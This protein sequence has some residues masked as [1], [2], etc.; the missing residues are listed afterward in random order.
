M[1]NLL[2]R[3]LTAVVAVPLLILAINWSDPIAVQ[4]IVVA[5]TGVG[6][7][8]W[9]RMTMT[10]SGAADR[11]FAIA[12]GIALVAVLVW[13]G[14]R[15]MVYPM[16]AAAATIAVLLFHLFHYGAM[17]TVAARASFA[18]A[19]LFYCGLLGFLARLKMRPDGAGW[20]YIA[21]TVSWLSDTGAYFAG[22]FLG[23]LWPAKLYPSVSPKKT[24]I[25][26][27]GGIAASYLSVLLAKLWYLPSLSWADTVLIAVPANLLGQT[28]DLC[29]SLVKRSVGVKDSGAL[30]PGHGG[31][32]DR[33]DA[34]LFVCP[35]VLAYATWVF[36]RI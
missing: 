24:I 6:L 25:G 19:G 7:R 21:L 34:L 20:V 9:M 32:L 14:D 8:E 13:L 30:L 28:G 23:P 27:F 36:G 4:L 35:Y 29:E 11:G 15:P 18:I 22:R 12:V 10:G 2:A 5:A 33:I 1:S 16:A 17:E 26:G 3:A 31:M